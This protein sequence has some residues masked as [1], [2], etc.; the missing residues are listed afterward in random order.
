MMSESTL[1]G[2][3]A[4]YSRQGFGAALTAQPPYALLIVGVLIAGKLAARRHQRSGRVDQAEVERKG[5]QRRH[6][7]EQEGEAG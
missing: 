1:P 6:Q 4:A 7:C 5:D 2:D 3:L